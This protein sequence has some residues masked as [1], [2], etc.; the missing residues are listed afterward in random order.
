MK[1]D[2]YI[3]VLDTETTD[4]TKALVY[5]L[6]YIVYDTT[7]ERIELEKSILVKEVFRNREA[8]L[9]AFYAN[10]I[11]S[12]LE[13]L[14]IGLRAELTV[15]MAFKSL[16]KDIKKYNISQ[17]YAYNCDFDRRALAFT[18]DFYHLENPTEKIE[19][20]DIRKYAIEAFFGKDYKEFAK[21]HGYISDKGYY[22]TTAEIMY[23]YITNNTGFIED[24]TALEDSKIE[25]EILLKSGIEFGKKLKN[26]KT[27]L[28]DDNFSETVT[29]VIDKKEILEIDY[30]SQMKRNNKIYFKTI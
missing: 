9:N 30:K 6:G 20:Y 23:R 2:N 3:L 16:E 19:F 5:D 8:M 29:I 28:K 7:R 18:T 27:F 1:K 15:K 17:I 11:G 12:Y 26:T 21:E 14:Y 22:K 10:K 13:D 4:L 24:H 25:L